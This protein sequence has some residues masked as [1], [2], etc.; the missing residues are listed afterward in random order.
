MFCNCF[1]RYYSNCDSYVVI[2]LRLPLLAI[3][4]DKLQRSRTSQLDCHCLKELTEVQNYR[5]IGNDLALLRHSV[6]VVILHEKLR[7]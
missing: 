1:D 5:V 7:M 3:V 2:T 6:I 4:N